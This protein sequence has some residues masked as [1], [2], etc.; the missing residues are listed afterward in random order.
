MKIQVKYIETSSYSLKEGE[1]ALSCDHE[2]AEVSPPCCSGFD[3]GLPS[4]G[5][6]GMYSVYCGDCDYMNMPDHEVDALI[7]ASIPEEPEY[8]PEEALVYA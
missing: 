5:C 8:E 4:C 6:G 2:L 7:E 1:T 3:A